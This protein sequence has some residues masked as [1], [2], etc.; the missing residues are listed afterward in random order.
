MQEYIRSR[1]RREF[2]EPIASERQ[3]VYILVELRKLLE[4]NDDAE[5]LPALNFYCDWSVHAV[6]DQEGAERIVRR[7]DEWQRASD[8]ARVSGV[9]PALAPHLKAALDQTTELRRFREQLAA[10]LARNELDSSIALTR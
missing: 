3:V 4:L 6:M 7:F 5:Q 8:E 10:Y 2:S 1:L 9:E